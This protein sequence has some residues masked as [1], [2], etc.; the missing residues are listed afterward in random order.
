MG[1]FSSKISSAFRYKSRIFSSIS[2]FRAI[3]NNSFF[4]SLI[5]FFNFFHFLINSSPLFK[6][7]RILFSF[8][9]FV[10]L[11]FLIF[12]KLLRLRLSTNELISPKDSSGKILFK[13]LLSNSVN[14]I[15]GSVISCCFKSCS[16]S[17][18]ILSFIYNSLSFS[19]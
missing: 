3:S 2:S 12:S 16:F 15:S 18:A 13:I 9:N 1:L 4:K 5:A 8:F 7:K 6:F 11:S 17:F 10:S 14:F 19:L